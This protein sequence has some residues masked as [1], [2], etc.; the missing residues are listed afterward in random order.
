MQPDDIDRFLHED[1]ERY[2]EIG[3]TQFTLG[4]GGPDW[5]VE[6]GRRFLEWR[7]RMNRVRG[8]ASAA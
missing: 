5:P 3:F 2:L 4:F 1:A 7:D 8:V 6:N